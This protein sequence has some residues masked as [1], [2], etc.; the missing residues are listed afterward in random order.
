MRS[1]DGPGVY[2][3][4]QGVLRAK[5]SASAAIITHWHLPGTLDTCVQAE[6]VTVTESLSS[7]LGADWVGVC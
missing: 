1:T 3:D 7:L 5:M 6:G 2:T 4:T